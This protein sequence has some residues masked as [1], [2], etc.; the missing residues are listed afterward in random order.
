MVGSLERASIGTGVAALVRVGPGAGEGVAQLPC[1]VVVFEPGGG[2]PGTGA[3]GSALEP[4]ELVLGLLVAV[5]ALATLA[6]RLRIAYPIV[7]V[8]GGLA[9][10]LVPGLPRVEL[11]PDV[12][13]IIFLP[14]LVY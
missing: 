13:F 3:R 6:R 5:A 7:L 12:V 14:P 8:L 9:L 4:I 2:G 1:L 10:G 11:P